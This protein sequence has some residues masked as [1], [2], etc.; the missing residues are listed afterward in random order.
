MSFLIKRNK[1]YHL[2]WYQ[3]KKTCPV[4]NGKK[5]INRKKCTR[6]RGT[7][8]VYQLCKKTISPDRQTALE[9]K[10]EFDRKFF[11]K[12]LGLQDTKKTWAS[13]VEEYLAY[14]KANKRPA[15]YTIDL[16]TIKGFT[17]IINPYRFTDITSQKIEQWKQKRLDT[18]SPAQANKEFRHLKSAL[19][20]AV[21][22]KYI[23][24]NPAKYI[25]QSK[26]PKNPPRFLSKEELK[27]LL[28]LSDD[29]MKLIIQAFI[30]TGIRI[31][32]LINLRW[33]DIDFK[34]REI[35]IQAHDNF[36]P[37]D[38]EARNIPTHDNLFKLLHPIKKEN[39]LV[40]TN[41]NKEKYTISS[42]EKQFERI[43]KKAGIQKCSPHS[44]RHT[45]ASHLVMSGIDLV[46][47]KEL[48]GHS[49]I[50]TTMIYAHL[51]KPHIKKAVSRL[52]YGL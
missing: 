39:G 48:L 29:K 46:T 23:D 6:C 5:I 49:T 32:E 20:K 25:K 30:Y 17:A 51:S 4:C 45:F 22:W 24:T 2:C 12:E 27:R 19:S 13:F 38:Y 28:L 11:R 31:S 35:I 34:R 41:E 36:Q 21:Q 42:L 33:Q 47:V 1:I 44:L 8:N 14:S 52:N 40:F 18:V 43:T 9:Y 26:I 50:T 3:G 10:T 16:R 15:T 37:K 7:G